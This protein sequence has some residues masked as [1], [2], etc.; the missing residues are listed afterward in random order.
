[1]NKKRVVLA[2]GSGFLGHALATTLRAR[3]YEVVVLTRS[4]RERGDGVQEVAWDGVQA[5][6]WI[7]ALEGA[8]AVVNL[9]GR[10]VDC[11][12]TPENLRVI[13]SSRVDSVKAVATGIL[14]V[15]RP[16]RVWVQAGATGFYGDRGGELC[17]EN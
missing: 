6:A 12:H 7:Q 15:T 14:Q 13:L 2:G 3:N 1:M 4:P 10:N 5:G 16:P 9:T 11:P 8:D 17:A